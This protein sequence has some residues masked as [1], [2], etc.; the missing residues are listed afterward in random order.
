[1]EYEKKKLLRVQSNTVA[2]KADVA[3]FIYKIL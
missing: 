3:L 2:L 1:V